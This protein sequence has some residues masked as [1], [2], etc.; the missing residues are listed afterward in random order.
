MKNSSHRLWYKT[1]AISICHYSRKASQV[2]WSRFAFLQYEGTQER[3]GDKLLS[4]TVKRL[5]SLAYLKLLSKHQQTLV[6]GKALSCA[7]CCHILLWAR[8][9]G[10][11][12]AFIE[13]GTNMPPGV[14]GPP[15]MWQ[16]L[17]VLNVKTSKA[18]A[19]RDEGI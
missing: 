6:Y 11:H 7:I 3:R 19:A 12:S 9:T 13:G 5:E 18:K 10:F 17:Y 14:T 16:K 4:Q 2:P 8:K 1:P 15:T